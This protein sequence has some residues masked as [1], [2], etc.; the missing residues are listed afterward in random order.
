LNQSQ[1]QSFTTNNRSPSPYDEKIRAATDKLNKYRNG[2]TENKYNRNTGR[3]APPR[4]ANQSVNF[5]NAFDRSHNKAY[6]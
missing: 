3:P 4:N 5:S 2:V 1:P 6:G